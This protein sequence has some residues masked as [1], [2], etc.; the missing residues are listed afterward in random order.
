MIRP[1]FLDGESRRDLI[2]LA[3]DGSAA[4]RLARRANALVLLDD[5]MSCEAIARVLLIDDDTI[6]TW[7]RPQDS[8]HSYIAPNVSTKAGCSISISANRSTRGRRRCSGML[9]MSS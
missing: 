7:F 5:G 1:G 9:G 2:E 6:R 4:H 8:P 3:R